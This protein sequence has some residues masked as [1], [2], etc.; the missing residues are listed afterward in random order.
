MYGIS[1]CFFGFLLSVLILFVGS[2]IPDVCAETE[3]V[4]EEQY[5]IVVSDYIWPD[6]LFLYSLPYTIKIGTTQIR[7]APGWS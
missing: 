3:W 6:I 1:A 5:D 7:I 2:C 4:I